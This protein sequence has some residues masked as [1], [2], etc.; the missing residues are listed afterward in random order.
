M[1]GFDLLAR[2]GGEEF[3]AVLVDVSM[4]KACF[5]AERLRRVIGGRPMQVSI[6]EGQMTVTTSLGGAYIG[7]DVVTVE[8]ALNRA[9]EKLYEAKESGR[10]AVVMERVGKLNPADYEEP[11]RNVVE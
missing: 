1:R 9:D 2:T 7:T 8:Q 11:K 5:I 6:P 4:E 10:D 3:V